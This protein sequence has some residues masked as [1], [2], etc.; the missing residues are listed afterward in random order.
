MKKYLAVLLVSPLLSATACWS[1]TGMADLR[2]TV[3]GSPIQG[4]ATLT[5]TPK[6]LKLSIEMSSISPGLHG[7]HIHE[8]G[9]CADFG[10]AAGSH[11]DPDNTRRHGQL[12]SHRQ[13]GV[14]AGDMGNLIADASG[15][16]VLDLTL[17]GVVLT[18]GKRS[19]AGRAIIIHDKQDDFGQ[20]VGNA[21]DRIACGPIVITGH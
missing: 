1:A 10:K 15:K 17:P 8:F 11:F 12:A 21:G 7:F 5:D 16:A 4:Q 14:H 19:V 20:P 6:G 3:P 2:A 13:H 9:S 18:G